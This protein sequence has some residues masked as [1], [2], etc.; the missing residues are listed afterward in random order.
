MTLLNIVCSSALGVF[1]YLLWYL[2]IITIVK[3]RISI[4]RAELSRLTLHDIDYT[5]SLLDEPK[6][7]NC[8]IRSVQ[9]RFHLPTPSLP[10]WFTLVSEGIT[11]FSGTGS[12]SI[13]TFSFTL[14]IFPVLFRHTAG[15]W[16]DVKI[17]GLKIQIP[18]GRTTPYFIQR[19]RTNLVNTL[20]RGETTRLDDFGTKLSFSGLTENT[21]GPE[22]NDDNH[23]HLTTVTNDC[24]RSQTTTPGLRAPSHSQSKDELRI[25]SYLHGFHI[26]NT[27][28]RIYTFGEVE[29]QLR[30]NWV[31]NRGSFV[32]VAE[33]SR[34]VR[35][36]WP[37]QRLKPLSPVA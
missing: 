36:H 11:Y 7:L 4:G 37:Y 16:V 13:E 31:E 27:E 25:S 3:Q 1:A 20:L 30:R 28:G 26:H 6:V 14:W 29:A 2:D 23:P 35:V 18:D 9:V 8:F 33:E 17:D 10:R 32:L 19:L 22:A 24:K 5:A 34:W 21:A 15:P 12:V